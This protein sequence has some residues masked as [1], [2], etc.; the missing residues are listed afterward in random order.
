[1]GGSTLVWRSPEYPYL[2]APVPRADGPD[3][4][5]LVAAVAGEGAAAV[6]VA[7]VLAR[8]ARAQEARINGAVADRGHP[9]VH[10]G[11]AHLVAHHLHCHGLSE[12][13]LADS[14]SAYLPETSWSLEDAPPEAVTPQPHTSA[15]SPSKAVPSS[16]L[17]RQAGVKVSR[18]TSSASSSTAMSLFRTGKP[19]GVE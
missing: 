3:E 14:V 17:A 19:P 13:L 7:R 10:G 1:M 18:S 8:G 9:G 4:H 6:A 11:G 15:V 12:Q 5:R 16:V 2:G